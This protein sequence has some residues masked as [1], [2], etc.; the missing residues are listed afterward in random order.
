MLDA[1]H[2]QLSVSA[3]VQRLFCQ[4]FIVDIVTDFFNK[5][6]ALVASVLTDARGEGSV[7]DH[8]RLPDTK[9]DWSIS[10]NSNYQKDIPLMQKNQIPG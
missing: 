1:F 8:V 9:I 10:G 3:T 4:L 7:N 2:W 5:T 6:V